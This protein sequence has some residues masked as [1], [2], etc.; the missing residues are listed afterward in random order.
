[1]LFSGK[2]T[3]LGIS[4]EAYAKDELPS[5]PPL[6]SIFAVNLDPS[7]LPSSHRVILYFGKEKA[8]Y[9]D[10]LGEPAIPVTTL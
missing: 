4:R 8:E 2:D 9:F 10:P 5:L 1:M 3:G 6:P 7:H